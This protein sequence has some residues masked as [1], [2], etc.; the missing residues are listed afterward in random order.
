MSLARR[1]ALI[2]LCARYNTPILED[3]FAG[4]LCYKGSPLPS[5]YTLALESGHSDLVIY[6]G[7]F[8]KAL[9]PGVRLGWLAAPEAVVEKLSFAKRTSD[10]ATNSMA[11]VILNEFLLRG[12]YQDHLASRQCRLQKQTRGHDRSSI[13]KEF[14]GYAGCHFFQT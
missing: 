1:K 9:C 6:Q 4:D 5:L 11:Q 2:E 10:L 7:T 8:S 3:D 13:E 14:N 12:L